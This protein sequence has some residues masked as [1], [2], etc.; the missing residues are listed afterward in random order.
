MSFRDE[1]WPRLTGLGAAR[2]KGADS[3]V[4]VVGGGGWLGRAT[5]EALHILLGRA[6]HDRVV[7]FGSSD[8]ILRLRGGLEV[9]QHPLSRLAALERRPSLVLHLAFL[10]QEKAKMMSEAD[11]VAANRAI[12]GAVRD[13]LDAI[14]ARGVL[15][16]SSGAVHLASHPDAEASKRLYGQLKLEDEAAFSRWGE[17]GH[18]AVA[19]ARIFN[20]AGP[21]LSTGGAY[22]L[23]AFIDDALR[24]GPIEIRARRP[25]IRSYVAISELMS[26]ALGALTASPDTVAFETQG[27]ADLEMA[28]IAEIV[29]AEIAPGIIIRRPP[30]ESREEDRYVGDGAAYRTLRHAFDVETVDFPAQVRQTA[31]CMTT[32]AASC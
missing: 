7:A 29:R 9:M 28:E 30:L 5:L 17:A 31:A 13:S 25:V 26:V 1:P 4:V 16:A 3:R 22:A 11:Y 8:R 23:A 24:G 2:L 15:V 32:A 18:G 14:G 19:V 12:S 10:T 6:F 27:D 21:Y 20:V